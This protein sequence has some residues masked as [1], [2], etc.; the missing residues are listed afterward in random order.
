L[1]ISDAVE[2]FVAARG[3]LL[4]ELAAIARRR[5]LDAERTASI[6]RAASILLDRLL[7]AFVTAHESGRRARGRDLDR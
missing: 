5:R 2:R 7:V 3:P 1:T 4:D 6:H